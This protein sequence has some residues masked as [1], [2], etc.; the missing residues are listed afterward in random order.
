MSQRVCSCSS[1][2]QLY[3]LILAC[4]HC[5][6]LVYFRLLG[7]PSSTSLPGSPLSRRKSA[8]DLR[9][10]AMRRAQQAAA[11][12]E[13]QAASHDSQRR[14]SSEQPIIAGTPTYDSQKR[15]SSE[16]PLVPGASNSDMQKRRSSEQL[17]LIPGS[18]SHNPAHRRSTEQIIPGL[19][20]HRRSEPDT[21][22]L[23]AHGTNST[24]PHGLDDRARNTSPEKLT[25]ES[26]V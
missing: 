11:A 24:Y 21:R 6:S 9:S 7:S 19:S 1:I 23:H 17:T 10:V 16:Q 22:R 3:C 4:S 13:K 5:D 15:R 2:M 26:L 12:V 18:S 20:M 14:R 8:A 25:E